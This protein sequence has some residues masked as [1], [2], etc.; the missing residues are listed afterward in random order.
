MIKK[1][2][3]TFGIHEPSTSHDNQ[4]VDPEEQGDMDGSHS[5]SNKNTTYNVEGQVD[6]ENGNNE[7]EEERNYDFPPGTENN[8]PSDTTNAPGPD[9]VSAEAEA[10]SAVQSDSHSDSVSQVR[11]PQLEPQ[12]ENGDPI[13]FDLPGNVSGFGVGV[14]IV[15]DDIGS[16]TVR[17]IRCIQVIVDIPP[18]G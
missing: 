11:L 2:K 7:D 10:T 6:W 18:Q 5:E 17:L 3:R 14:T 9:T 8:F 15:G 1:R 12:E 16:V 4:E 13:Y